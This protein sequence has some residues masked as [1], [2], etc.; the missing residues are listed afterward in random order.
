M[1]ALFSFHCKATALL[2]LSLS[3]KILSL[4][5]ANATSSIS[6]SGSGLYGAQQIM[7]FLGFSGQNHDEPQSAYLQQ[8]IQVELKRRLS[9]NARIFLDGEEE[10]HLVD[11]RYTNYRRPIYIAGVKVAEE[12]DVVETVCQLLLLEVT[13]LICSGNLCPLTR[14]PVHGPYWGSFTNNFITTS[15]KRNCD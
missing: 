4:D 10:F 9:P 8:S 7:Q 5:G 2:L 1:P 15:S 12:R 13:W 14:H 6:P 3:I 11:A